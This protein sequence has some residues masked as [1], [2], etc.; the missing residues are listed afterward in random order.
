M[1][2]GFWRRVAAYLADGIILT[3]L[4][5][6]IYTLAVLL[7]DFSLFMTL[8]MNPAQ[9]NESNIKQFMLQA[10]ALNLLGNTGMWLYYALF[11]ASRLQG[12]PGRL[13][14]GMKVTDKNG[15]RISFGRATGRHFAKFISSFI[16]CIGYI[17]VAFTEK[18]R[19][20]HD[21]IAGTLVIRPNYTKVEKRKD[22]DA[23]LIKELE[24]G[25]IQDYDELMRRKAELL[26]RPPVITVE[27]DIPDI[28]TLEVLPASTTPVEEAKKSSSLFTVLL[29]LLLAA[30][31]IMTVS[32]AVPGLFGGIASNLDPS[33]EP[34]QTACSTEGTIIMEINGN[35]YNIHPVAEYILTARVVSTKKYTDVSGE[36]APMDVGTA[37]GDIGT[38]QYDEY[39][40]FNHG[41][42]T[43]YTNYY[44]GC[45]L[46]YEYVKN[47][48]SNNHIV[49]SNSNISRAVESLKKDQVIRIEG[50]LVNIESHLNGKNY[51]WKTSL[52]RTDLDCE[53]VYVKRIM[54]GD[55]AYE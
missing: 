30:I 32:I 45:P 21:M 16:L 49:A 35:K 23:Y 44:P 53:Y 6:I 43:L 31:V 24:A 9:A 37:W 52:S 4:L 25:R 2:G 15:N 50:Y 47:H 34:V 51:N 26:G 18:K 7:L 13:L 42:R 54:V 38:P 12:T 3:V 17:M 28:S 29:I 19:G 27:R 39:L 36:I 48:C 14:L 41:D 40:T 20:L 8:Y 5:G 1:Y 10:L 22:I 11:E 33:P 55:K 46:D